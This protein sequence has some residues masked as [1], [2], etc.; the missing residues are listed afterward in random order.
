MLLMFFEKLEQILIDI[1]LILKIVYLRS[2]LT[3]KYTLNTIQEI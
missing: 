3:K 1:I 2:T